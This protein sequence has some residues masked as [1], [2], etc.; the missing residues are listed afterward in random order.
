MIFLGFIYYFKFSLLNV[1]WRYDRLSSCTLFLGKIVLNSNYN[2]NFQK[3]FLQICL[4]ESD[5]IKF[6]FLRSE[7]FKTNIDRFDRRFVKKYSELDQMKFL[8]MEAQIGEQ[9]GY[10]G[11]NHPGHRWF[12]YH[13]K[14]TAEGEGVG[15]SEQAGPSKGF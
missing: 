5:Q 15:Q 13:M 1:S 7:I 3:N 6:D 12:Q 14:Y 4:A 2:T 9:T 10:L 11:G 8:G